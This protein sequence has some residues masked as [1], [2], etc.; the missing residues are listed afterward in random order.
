MSGNDL[1]L[2]ITTHLIFSQRLGNFFFL[3]STCFIIFKS[4]ILIIS[5][6]TIV[7]HF[8]S[9]FVLQSNSLIFSTSS[10][11]KQVPHTVTMQSERLSSNE[12]KCHRIIVDL[13]LFLT[14]V[15]TFSI[16]LI[17]S[18]V[19]TG[20]CVGLG[21]RKEIHSYYPQIYSQKSLCSGSKPQ[22]RDGNDFPAHLT[23]LL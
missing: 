20:K 15:Q 8:A 22:S 16:S 6:F 7:K 23:G 4:A 12:Y 1:I 3:F 9:W 10:N 2:T 14:Q 19:S 5:V 17:I 21:A 18:L 13:H 11:Q